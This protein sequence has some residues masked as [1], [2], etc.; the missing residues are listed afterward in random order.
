MFYLDHLPTKNVSIF[1]KDGCR[2]GAKQNTREMEEEE[3]IRDE[4]NRKKK[5]KRVKENFYISNKML[6]CQG[7]FFNKKGC[8]YVTMTIFS[9]RLMMTHPS[10]KKETEE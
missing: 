2:K 5:K 4:R 6:V 10:A 8:C 3:R 1:E 9:Y 7:G